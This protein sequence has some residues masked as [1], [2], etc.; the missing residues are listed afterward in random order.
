MNIN[1]KNNRLDAIFEQL[2]FSKNKKDNN[3]NKIMSELSAEV[4]RVERE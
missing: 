1:F 3:L 4:K 2:N